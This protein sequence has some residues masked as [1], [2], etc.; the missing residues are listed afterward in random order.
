MDRVVPGEQQPESDHNYKG[1]QTESGVF[2]DRHWRHASRW[3]SYDLR[4][5]DKAGRKLRVTYY[6]LDKDRSFDIYVNDKLLKTVQLDGTQETRSSTLIMS[7][8][9]R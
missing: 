9:R 4:N 3:F 8:R 7:C 5:K 1:E 2:R 6:G